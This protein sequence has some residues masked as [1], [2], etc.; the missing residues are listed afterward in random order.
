MIKY[1]TFREPDE[2]NGFSYFILQK[3]FPHILCKLSDIP[4]T[5]VVMPVP[6][7]DYNL[8]LNFEGLLRGRFLPSYKNILDQVSEVM[9][10]MGL[11]FL[12]NRILIEPKRYKKWKM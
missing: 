10:D 3:E 11:W 1:L 8:F 12:Q 7:N 2:S 5:Y 9:Q 6:I 4:V